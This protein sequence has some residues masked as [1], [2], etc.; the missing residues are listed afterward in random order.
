MT[1]ID[2]PPCWT[3]VGMSGVEH[4]VNMALSVFTL[5]LWLPFYA[6]W[7]LAVRNRH[8]WVY[9]VGPA[10]RLSHLDVAII[11]IAVSV[12][13]VLIVAGWVSLYGWTLTG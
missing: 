1:V 8:A 5:G 3:R 6:L 4:V 10:R 13:I 12:S 2:A 11:T 9:G 7:W